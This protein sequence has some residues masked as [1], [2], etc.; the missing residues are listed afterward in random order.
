MG[1]SRGIGRATAVLA[2]SYGANVILHGKT[3][4][5]NLISLANKLNARYI[6]SDVSNQ[7]S[8]HEAIGTIE[9][10]IDAMIYCSGI[11][12]PKPFLETTEDDWMEEFRTNLF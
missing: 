4:S 11:V 6:F 9:E 2:K 8:T 5:E 1:S 7:K 3:E 10:S 12:K